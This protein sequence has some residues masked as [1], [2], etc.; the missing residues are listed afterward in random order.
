MIIGGG[1]T[2]AGSGSDLALARIYDSGDLD[3]D[4]GIAGRVTTDIAGGDD[5]IFDIASDSSGRLIAV[6]YATVQGHL[7]AVIARYSVAP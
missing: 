4:F 3:T 6:G 2:V 1:A 7:V 5:A